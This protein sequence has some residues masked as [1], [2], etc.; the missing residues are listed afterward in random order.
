MHVK[1]ITTRITI[2]PSTSSRETLRFSRNKIHCSPRDQSLSVKWFLHIL[3]WLNGLSCSQNAG[4]WHSESTKFQIS[5]GDHAPNPPSLVGANHSCKIL[6][7]PLPSYSK[8]CSLRNLFVNGNVC[9]ISRSFEEANCAWNNWWI[10]SCI[11]ALR[12]R[13]CFYC[14]FCTSF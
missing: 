4:K 8:L 11:F 1:G 7:P 5:L 6:D 2:F 12:P 14:L 9:Q 13:H 3:M 10:S